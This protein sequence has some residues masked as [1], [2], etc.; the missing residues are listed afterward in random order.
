MTN[1]KIEKVDEAIV[2]MKAKIARDSAK[3]RELERQRT[4]FENDEIVSLFRRENLTDDDIAYLVRLKAGRETK[5]DA[6][7][8]TEAPESRRPL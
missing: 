8:T 7:E 2:K 3:L 6:A 5:T 4:L 1:P